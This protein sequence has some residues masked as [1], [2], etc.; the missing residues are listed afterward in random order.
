MKRGA[1]ARRTKGAGGKVC[2]R[3]ASGPLLFDSKRPRAGELAGPLCQP[4]GP[5]RS[6]EEAGAGWGTRP[7][8]WELGLEEAGQRAGMGAQEGVFSMRH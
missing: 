8:G 7:V 2:P 5:F 6:C 3:V 4:A 1:G